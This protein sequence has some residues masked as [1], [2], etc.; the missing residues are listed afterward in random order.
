V[1]ISVNYDVV[2]T[3]KTGLDRWQPSLGQNEDQ[4]PHAWC[5]D[6]EWDWWIGTQR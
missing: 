2:G 4:S 1:K 5:V 6:V 3:W